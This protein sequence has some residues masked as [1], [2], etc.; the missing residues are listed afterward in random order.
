MT[1]ISPT[2]RPMFVSIKKN[3]K[4]FKEIW[5]KTNKK[6]VPFIVD[7]CYYSYSIINIIIDTIIDILLMFVSIK[8]I[9]KKLKETWNKTI[10][11]RV[12]FIVGHC[13]NCYSIIN[14]II[15]NKY[16]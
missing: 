3:L 2:L 8:K 4:K 7:H 10:K 13:Y 16:E 12:P 14:I 6:C 5:N 1:A 9:K 15:D 11:K